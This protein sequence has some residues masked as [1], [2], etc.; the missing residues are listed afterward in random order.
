MTSFRSTL[1][2]SAIVLSSFIRPISVPPVTLSFGYL[3]LSSFRF[4][5]YCYYEIQNILINLNLLNGLLV[6]TFKTTHLGKVLCGDSSG[7]FISLCQF[8]W[9]HFCE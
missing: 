9:S 2:L 5:A 8:L 4:N 7:R 3:S 6:T 1:Y